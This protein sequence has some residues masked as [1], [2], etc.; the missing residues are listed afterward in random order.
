MKMNSIEVTN[1]IMNDPTLSLGRKFNYSLH[2]DRV[3]NSKS[4]V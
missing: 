2:V 1:S 4:R 3:L